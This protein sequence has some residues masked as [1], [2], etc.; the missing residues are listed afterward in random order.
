[1]VE[2]SHQ[3][4]AGKVA[5]VTGSSRGLGA[6]MATDLAKRGA[7]V[8][9]TYTS[10]NSKSK[11][12]DLVKEIQSYGNGSDAIAVGG[13]LGKVETPDHIVKQTLGAFGDKIDILVNNAGVEIQKP[14]VEITAEDHDKLYNVNVRAPHLMTRA[15][16]PHLRTPARII[17]LSSIGARLGLENCSLYCS[18]KAALEGATRVWATEFGPKGTTVNCVA[19]GPVQ[20]D[21]LANF[22]QKIIDMQK[23]QTAVEKRLG[24]SQDIANIVAWLAGPES[25]WVSGQCISASGGYSM[26]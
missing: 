12:E 20:S 21:M 6:N 1:M 19:P 18:S 4:L 17:N 5:I 22:P 23:E 11:A 10:P 25:G 3:T 2:L 8:V 14:M 24:T 16:A 7:K 13:D 26:Y 15:V 9:I